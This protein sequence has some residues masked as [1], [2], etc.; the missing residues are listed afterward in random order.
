MTSSNSLI[1][2]GS[3][4]VAAATLR[5]LLDDAHFAIEAV[6]T[7]P[8][9]AGHRGDVPVVSLADE[10]NL[11][12]HTPQTKQELTDLFATHNFTS[13]LGVVVDYG[14]IIAQSVIDAFPKGIINS[15]FSLLPEW[16]GA[17]PIT[18]ALLSGQPQTGVS[19]MLINDKL[20]E[21]DLLQ[22]KPYDIAANCII[23]QLTDDLVTLSNQM[24]AKTIPRYIAGEITPYTQP[25]RPASYSRKL[26][27]QDGVIDW[28]KTAPQL[29]REVRAF[30]GWPKS[31]AIVFEQQ[32]VLLWA[33]VATDAQDGALVIAC[34]EGSYLEILELIGPSGKRMS[35][36]A[37][38]R[39]YA[40][41]RTT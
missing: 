41:P 33:R 23:T 13:S 20:D 21:G 38:M 27:K 34:G 14:I 7:K 12:T 10:R 2:F 15:H 24:L 22:Q 36:E 16:R 3:G 6:I 25:N 18:F 28:T 29:E 9:A 19:L 39:G 26:T 35:G 40:R 8:R 30:L 1:F 4:P 32:I 5:S 11:T 31:R 17:D 37:F